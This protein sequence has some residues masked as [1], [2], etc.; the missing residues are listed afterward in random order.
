MG[1]RGYAE[2]TKTQ[3]N[4]ATNPKGTPFKSVLLV[5]IM[6]LCPQVNNKQTPP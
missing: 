2:D 6:S 1:N 5:T 4:L 3:R